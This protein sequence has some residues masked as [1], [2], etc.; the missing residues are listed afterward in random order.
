[1]KFQLVKALYLISD[2]RD[3]LSGDNRVHAIQLAELFK[4]VPAALAAPRAAPVAGFR[5]HPFCA[6]TAPAAE[7]A[8]NR[9]RTAPSDADTAHIS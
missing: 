3:I 5:L 6:G 7:G 2:I 1:M 8:E 4:R 9:E